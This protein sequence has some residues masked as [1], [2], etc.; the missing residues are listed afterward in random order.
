MMKDCF[1]QDVVD[2]V[3]FR[4]C[5][6][7][8]I[9]EECT[10]SVYLKGALAADRVGQGL[11]YALAVTGLAVAFSLWGDMPHGSPWLAFAALVYGLAIYRAGRESAER[12]H[13]DGERM[14]REAEAKPAATPQVAAHGAHH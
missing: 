3:K 6:H 12:V 9:F 7:C 8:E 10:K 2:A 1:K 5:A 14:L 11:G 4:E 13:D